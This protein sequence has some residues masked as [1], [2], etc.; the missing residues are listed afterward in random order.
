MAHE[1]K[2]HSPRDCWR[3][4]DFGM[5]LFELKQCGS[6]LLFNNSPKTNIMHT[7]LER[8]WWR[9]RDEHKLHKG[10]MVEEVVSLTV[11]LF[12]IGD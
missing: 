10:T 3:D 11:S 8:R 9:E 6:T 2:R 4:P 7:G 5:A 1:H 12:D